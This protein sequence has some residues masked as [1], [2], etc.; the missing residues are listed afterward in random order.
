VDFPE[1]LSSTFPQL[2]KTK[3]VIANTQNLPTSLMILRGLKFR[4]HYPKRQCFLG[5]QSTIR[6]VICLK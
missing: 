4:N 2:R 3:Y 1:L 5:I 6:I